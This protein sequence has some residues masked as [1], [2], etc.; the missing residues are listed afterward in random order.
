MVKSSPTRENIAKRKSPPIKGGRPKASRKGKD[1]ELSVNHQ[2]VLNWYFHPSVN[3]SKMKA[4]LM[5]GYSEST[6]RTQAKSVFEREDMKRAIAQR[7]EAENLRFAV[8]RDWIRKH[9]VMLATAMPAQI[10]LKLDENNGD[11]NCLTPEELYQIG[12]IKERTYMQGRGEDA[13]PVT[14][15]TFKAENRTVALGSLAKLE[16]LNLEKP[17]ETTVNIVEILNQG[18][19]QM[20][21]P[22]WMKDGK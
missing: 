22:P 6:A 4:L 16:G 17:P 14:E 5:A 1:A 13:V 11:M 12:E 9:Y 19:A 7:M 21:R 15:R 18:R 2:R 20:K 10:M 3:L 8:D